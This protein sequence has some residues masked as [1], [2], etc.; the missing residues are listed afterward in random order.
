[1]TYIPKVQSGSRLGSMILDHFCMTFLAMLFFIPLMVQNISGALTV[2]HT[3]TQPEF[4]GPFLFFALLGFA[5]YLCKD[6]I[7]GRSIGKR[8]TNTQVVDNKTGHPATPLQTLIRNI[9]CIIWP[10]E[11]II[12]LVN[13]ERRIGDR[14]AGTRIALYDRNAKSD[15]KFDVKQAAIALMVAYLVITLFTVTLRSLVPTPERVNYLESSYNE[16]ASRQ[17]EKLFSDS[18]GSYLNASVKVYDTV[19]NKPGKYI[20]IIYTLREDYLEDDA[21]YQDL[22]E[23]TEKLLYS[24]HPKNTFIGQGKYVFKESGAIRVS[25]SSIGTN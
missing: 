14:I 3:P 12:I 20:S 2:S 19:E 21:Q 6:I 5:I 8:V 13:P 24:K 7:H 22:R 4:D 25:T 18:L 17:L 10:V 15:A 9:T 23:M 16:T 11:V 1:M